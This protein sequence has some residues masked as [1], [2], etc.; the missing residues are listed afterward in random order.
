M[1]L[2]IA[3]LAALLYSV[4]ERNTRDGF[5]YKRNGPLRFVRVGRVSFSYCIRK[6]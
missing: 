4:A 6:A 1:F 5:S 3:I 2:F